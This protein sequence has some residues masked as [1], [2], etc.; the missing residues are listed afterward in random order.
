MLGW[1]CRLFGH[2]INR[3][4]VWNDGVDFRTTCRRC[5]A[6]LLRGRDG[7]RRFDSAS[8]SSTAR[9]PHPRPD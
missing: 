5:G 3:R 6:P 9:D 8:D 2:R 1:I 4:R 7:W